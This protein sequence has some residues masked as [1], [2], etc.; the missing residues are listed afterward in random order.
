MT[1]TIVAWIKAIGPAVKIRVRESA[2]TPHPRSLGDEA[3]QS[4]GPEFPPER[5][6]GEGAAEGQ[7]Q[8]A[9]GAGS[10][11]STEGAAEQTGQE[12]EEE[13]R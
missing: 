10:V 7:A 8:D 1:E 9:Q 12:T 5:P 13:D 6:E 11:L 2:G 3:S 4:L